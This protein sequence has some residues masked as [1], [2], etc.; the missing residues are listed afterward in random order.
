VHDGIHLELAGIPA[1]TICTD[2]FMAPSRAMA[3]MW[4]APAYPII[5]T[6]HPISTLTRAQLRA[7]AV[8]MLDEIVRIVTGGGPHE[9][10]G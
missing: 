9:A 5:F 2:I 7:R 1:V 4:G 6:P 10:A 3:R 8:A